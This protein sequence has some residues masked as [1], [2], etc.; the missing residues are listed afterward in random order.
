M[1]YQTNPLAKAVLDLFAKRER[2]ATETK[3]EALEF[4]LK[5]AGVPSDHYELVKVLKKL[6]ELGYGRYWVGRKG[7]STRVVWLVGIVSLGQ[8]A[9]SARSEIELLDD[10]GAQPSEEDAG[11]GPSASTT[12]SI[13]GL[14]RIV[15]PLRR[16]TD[17]EL[18]IPR[19]FQK[20]DAERL[21]E[22][23]KTLPF[24]EQAI[25]H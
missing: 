24:D 21:I 25:S 19:D 16:D 11:N 15:Y 1:L 9:A 18:L 2:N 3:V 17:V 10:G 13:S 8:A 14:K 4:A 23:I 22:F 6:C 5:R 12:N 7:H 20:K